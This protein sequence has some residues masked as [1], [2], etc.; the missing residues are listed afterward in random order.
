MAKKKKIKGKKNLLFYRHLENVEETEITFVSVWN[1]TCLC[2]LHQ[3]FSIVFAVVGFE[4]R[5]SC[6][7]GT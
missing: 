6:M 2:V 4:P 7:P 1:S 3:R 5:I